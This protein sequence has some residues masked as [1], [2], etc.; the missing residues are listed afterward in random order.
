[1]ENSAFDQAAAVD[2]VQF[3]SDSSLVDVLVDSCQFKSNH[4]S[5][6]GSIRISG[7]IED[8]IVSNSIFDGNT[9]EL[10]TGGPAFRGSAI[11][12]VYNCIMSFNYSGLSDST[13]TISN[14]SVGAET[15]VDLINCTFVDSSSASGYAISLRRGA[16]SRIT[17][18]ILW[19]CG[20]H[21][22]SIV[23]AADLG[24]TVDVNYCNIENG[25]DSIYVSDTASVL[26]WGVGNIAKDPR[27]VDLAGGDFHL[28]D[29]S[30]CIGAGINSF[31]LNE[32]EITAP[33]T[34]IEGNPRPDPEGTQADLGAIEN[35]LGTPVNTG[36]NQDRVSNGSASIQNYPNPFRTAT[37]F[38]YQLSVPCMVNLNIYNIHG[39][40]VATVVSENQPAGSYRVEWD[41][42]KFSSGT[43][44]YRL[45]TEKG[46]CPTGK[47]LIL[48]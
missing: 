13:K 24:C 12:K 25:I 7:T 36:F 31:M 38:T 35:A 10:I 14:A 44:L 41:G 8:F 4:S 39:Q 28:M 21:P 1:M 11:G 23:T 2:I 34:D 46:I 48:K 29:S 40:L 37:T 19:G 42:S 5:R 43:Y 18:C 17:N 30:P 9:T 3:T 16:E 26:N 15:R 20:D 6:L 32:Q 27:F 22:I 33:S 47:M 45:E